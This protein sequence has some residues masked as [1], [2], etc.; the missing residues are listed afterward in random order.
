LQSPLAPCARS[1]NGVDSSV[2]IYAAKHIM[3]GQLIYKDIVDHKGP[4]LYVINVI[5]LFIGGGKFIGIWLLEV[6][7]LFVTSII[8]YKTARLFANKLSSVLAVI[9][10]ML[11][12]VPLLIGG[13][14]TEEW[15]LPYISIALYIFVSYTKK[16]VP[17][18]RRQLFVLALSFTLTFLLR[19]NLIAP[20][21]GYGIALIIQW[22]FRK[23][24]HELFRCFLWVVLYISLT[25]LPFLLYFYYNHILADAIY[26][27]FKFNI[28]EYAP[29]DTSNIKRFIH[30]IFGSSHIGIL[31]LLLI[32][33]ML[34]IKKD[35]E[36]GL[37]LA[38]IFSIIICSMGYDSFQHY[39]I[40][41]APLF[42]I[43]LTYLYNI[44]IP[45]AKY[46]CLLTLFLVYNGLNISRQMHC[47]YNNYSDVSSDFVIMSPAKMDKLKNIII[48]NTKSSDK[49]LVKGYQT[50]IYLYTNR[51]CATRFPYPLYASSLAKQCY[52][53]DVEEKLP[54][55]IVQEKGS[56]NSFN[57]EPLLSTKYQSVETNMEDME[58]WLLVE[59]RK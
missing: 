17:F 35:R 54:K 28:F 52:I 7:S 30:I 36:G 34:Y 41:F 24:Y 45:K 16:G 29:S 49:I 25:I 47:I 40:I 19:P 22:V 32:I 43:L 1:I 37:L 51:T 55:I 18:T 27:L 56:F 53:K 2:F 21:V 9:S 57:L 26:L 38:F 33:Y 50:A 23:Q 14:F 4:F 58:V 5:G 12:L 20:W 10:S 11:Y 13:N 31:P 48:Q 39:F 3:D 15:A 46:A 42:A 44:H 59:N 8:S 6:L